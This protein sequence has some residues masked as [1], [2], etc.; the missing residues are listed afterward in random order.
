MQ[1]P[2]STPGIFTTISG[3]T[4]NVRQ[5]SSSVFDIG[6]IARSL[7]ML[8]RYVGHMNHFY[9]VAEH[10][11]LVSLHCGDDPLTCMWGLLHDAPEYILGDMSA[12][13]KQLPELAGYRI[14]ESRLM[15]AIASA[16]RLPTK[17]PRIVHEIDI[18]I[19]VNERKT[20]QNVAPRKGQSL[21]PLSLGC[22][23]SAKAESMF[24]R[25]FGELSVSCERQ[26]NL[27]SQ[28]S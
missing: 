15:L 4:V 14:L 8:P 27:V 25:R 7:S 23:S 18:A 1:D 3:A 11:F 13:V 5:P 16:Y 12:P 20:L 28:E 17:Q 26:H 2:T 24:I 21:L 22:W 10:C 6:D 9:S 19:R